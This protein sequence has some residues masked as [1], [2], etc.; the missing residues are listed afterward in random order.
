MKNIF[1]ISFIILIISINSQPKK[2]SPKPPNKPQNKPSNKPTPNPKA[3]QQNQ[4]QI[5]EPKNQTEK[6]EFNLTESLI[7][8]FNEMF[9]SSSNKTNQTQKTEEEKLEE[10]KREEQKKKE[11]E[12]K[13]KILEQ[14][15]LEKEKAELK[16]KQKRLQ[17]EKEREEFEK[18]IENISVSEFVNLY[19]E[20]KSGELLYHNTTKPC[21]IKIIFLLTDMERTIHLVFNGPNIRGGS[22]LI[23][24][25]RNKNFLYYEYD[26]KN[27][28]QYSFYLNNYH[29]SEE[30]EIVFAVDDDSKKSE[31]KLEKKKIDK[32]SM[33]LNEIDVKVNT[34]SVKQNLVNRKTE[35]HNKSVDKHN[36]KIFIY[37]IIEV[38]TMI[39]VFLLQ[40]CYI[41]SIVEKI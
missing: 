39:V 28:G 11:E 32:I 23:Q 17:L 38:I 25:F 24:S 20:P 36:K 37:S 18:K 19:L 4:K 13:R 21:K 3:Q 34:M 33:Y 27:V 41:K 2:P 30:T 29:N 6:K 12:N 5:S 7:N 31:E 14:I 10:K 40:T 35:R 22:S 9:G 16:K 15:N 8:F 26:A 1:L